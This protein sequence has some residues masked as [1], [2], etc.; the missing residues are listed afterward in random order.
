MVWSFTSGSSAARDDADLAVAQ[1]LHG[2]GRR[3]PAGVDLPGHHLRERAGKA[4]GGDRLGIDLVFFQEAQHVRMRGCAD[5]G[6]RNRAAAHV[7]H[8]LDRRIR[9]HVPVGVLAGRLGADDADRRA[10]RIGA[11]HAQRADRH[12]DIDVA[13]D[14]GLHRL[15][16]ALGVQNLELQPMLLEKAGARTERCGRAMPDLALADG[17]L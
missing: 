14:H 12:A 4:A 6:K 1:R 13:G 15:P 11:E 8:R 10:F 2:I 16:G 17:D 9:A 7:G 5:R 3:R